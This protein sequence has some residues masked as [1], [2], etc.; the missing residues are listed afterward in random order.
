[1]FKALHGLKSF[2]ESVPEPWK[3]AL[4]WIHRRIRTALEYRRHQALLSGNRDLAEPANRER[5]F[6][7]ANGPSVKSQDLTL[8]KGETVF[9]MNAFHLH[10][11][12]DRIDP[13]YHCVVDPDAFVDTP[14]CRS[15][16]SDLER[17]GRRVAFL[18]PVEAAGL[19]GRLGLFRERKVRYLF[20]SDQGCESG[21]IRADLTRP[22]SSVLCVTLACLLAAAWM[23][24]KNVY[25][26]GCDHDWLASP[27]KLAHFYEQDPAAFP[28][29]PMTYEQ[30]MESQLRLWRSYRHVREFALKRGVRIFNATRGGYLDVFPRAAYEPLFPGSP[31]RT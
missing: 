31:G 27:S 28:E 5:C 11:D 19:I 26:L 24:F 20:L 13:T 1:M 18:F 30:L 12:Y 6:I 7:V 9:V 22:L 23:R 2:K 3:P 10:P 21:R 4:R 8:L 14:D 16:L 17:V 29:V 25:L 15:W